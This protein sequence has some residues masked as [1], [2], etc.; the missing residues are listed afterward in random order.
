MKLAVVGTGYVGL[1]AAVGFCELG[2]QVVCVDND[3]PKLQKIR[4]G[5][6]PFYEEHLKQLV[7]RHA[8][9][10]LTFSVDIAPAVQDSDVIFIAVGTPEGGNGE[11]D[12]SYVEAVSREIATAIRSYKVIVEKSTVPVYTNHWIRRPCC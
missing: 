4:D 6:M 11:A 10:S 5:I 7:R 8:G 1:V 2:H 9:S 12:L 3:G